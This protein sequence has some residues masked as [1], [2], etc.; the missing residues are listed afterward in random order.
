MKRLAVIL[1]VLLLTVSCQD[2]L[3]EE[4]KSEQS[5]DQFFQ[6]P[7]EATSF[8]NALYR[9][10]ATNFYNTGGFRGSVVMMGGY[11]SGLFDNEAKGE[12]IEPMRAQE[13]SFNSMNM[14]EYL[15]EWWSGAYNAIATANTAIQRIPNTTGLSEA[16]A[17]RLLAEARFF[18]AFNYFFL[19]K[20][21][22]GVPLVTEPYLSIEGIYAERNSD[23]EVYAQIV[24]DLE[25]ALNEGGLPDVAFPLNGFRITRGAVAGLLADVHLQM[26]G[27]PVQAA[28]SYA[29]AANAAREVIRGGAHQLIENGSTPETSAYNVMRTSDVEREYV[30]SIEYEATISPNSAPVNALPG[31]VR[32]PDIKYSRTHVNYRPLDEFVEIYEVDKDLR[33]QNKQLFHTS[34][35][36]DGQTFEF[37]VYTPYLFFDDTAIYETGRGDK[38]ISVM[39]YAEVLLIAAEAIARSEG[40]TDEAIG[41]LADV[42][43]R[44]YWQTDQSEIENE[45]R[46]LSADEFV[47]EVWTERLRELALDYKIWSDIQRTRKYPVASGGKVQFVDVIGHTNPWGATYQEHHLLWPISDNEMQR[48]PALEQNPGY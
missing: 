30:Y 7:K 15:Y 41:Y 35:E 5:L 27:Y 46:G 21:F 6:S 26:A 3:V 25:W 29:R 1:A 9:R 2:F 23:A 42:R 31:H 18:R 28:E 43:S 14:A 39:R 37:G 16:E 44:A 4:P 47:E 10:G 8:V 33:I 11:L 19:V 38:D 48:N 24:E 17:N 20:N 45:L 40:V 34:L 32:P 36:R 12:R 22:G 13:L